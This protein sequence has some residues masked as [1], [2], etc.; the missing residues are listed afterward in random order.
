[1]PEAA[2]HSIRDLQLLLG[3]LRAAAGD[4]VA[5]L[6]TEPD[7]PASDGFHEANQRVLVLARELAA[8]QDGGEK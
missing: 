7:G 8:V 3:A 6:D 4:A 2:S 5:A 1:M